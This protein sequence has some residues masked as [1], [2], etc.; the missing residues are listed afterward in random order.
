MENGEDGDAIRIHTI[1]D[2]VG[3]IG[4]GELPRAR[5]DTR[6]SGQRVVCEIEDGALDAGDKAAAGLSAAT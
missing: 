2:K 1:D 3:G 5:H 4:D 6:R